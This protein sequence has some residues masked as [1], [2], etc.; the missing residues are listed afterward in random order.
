MQGGAVAMEAPLRADDIEAALGRSSWSGVRS[1]RVVVDDTG[2]VILT[3][4]VARYYE[5]QMALQAVQQVPGVREVV[6]Q[7]DVFHW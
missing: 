7:I 6:D 1:L 5:K 3:G 2:R 4:Y